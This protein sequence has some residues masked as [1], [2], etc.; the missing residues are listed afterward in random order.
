VRG[1]ARLHVGIPY[2]ETAVYGDPQQ[3]GATES[4]LK[5]MWIRGDWEV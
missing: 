4:Q 1:G 2:V 5:S 3:E